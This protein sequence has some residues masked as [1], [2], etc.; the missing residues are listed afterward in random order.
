MKL[1]SM[2]YAQVNEDTR[3]QLLQVSTSGANEATRGVM[4]KIRRIIEVGLFGDGDPHNQLLA[5][6]MMAGYQYEGYNALAPGL[7]LDAV[8]GVG[9]GTSGPGAGG[10]G[11]AGKIHR[12]QA[13][14]RS[15]RQRQIPAGDHYHRQ[16]VLTGP[17]KE[18]RP[19]GPVPASGTR[20]AGRRSGSLGW[21]EPLLRPYRQTWARP[22]RLP[23]GPTPEKARLRGQNDV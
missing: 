3:Q 22:R 1:V 16:K 2:A 18:A 4:G 13:S 20:R 12:G 10:L 15:H 21:G 14:R 7:V 9:P 19:G 11:R 8:Y 5:S 23:R 6:S 17:L